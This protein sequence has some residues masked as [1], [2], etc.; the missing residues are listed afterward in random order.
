[1]D[2]DADRMFAVDENGAPVA[3]SVIGAV[4]ADR[5]LRRHPGE[6]VLHNLICS[7]TVPETIEAAGG[8]PVRT[9]VGHSF[10]KEVM[11]ETGAIFAVE[12]SGHYYFREN[13][14]ADSGLI[15]AMFLL[16]AICEAGEPLSAVVA[17]HDRYPASGEINFRVRDQAAATAAVA[18]AFADADIDELD[19][20]TVRLDDG[21]F[22]LRASNTEPLLRL[23]VEGDTRTSMERIRDQVAA[24]VQ[25]GD[26]DS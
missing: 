26:G 1:F 18:R 6:T 3:S 11:A 15:A 21:W 17:P 25:A 5:L 2:G 14:R 8:T 12:H 9:R 23:N 13:F 7:R 16:E 22:N 24:T 20:L 10:I 19:G 4:V